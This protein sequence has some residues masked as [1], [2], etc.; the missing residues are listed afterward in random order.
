MFGLRLAYKQVTHKRNPNVWLQTS[1]KETEPKRYIGVAQGLHWGYI[2]VT[3]GLHWGYIY[4]KVFD[5]NNQ[6]VVVW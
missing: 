5:L 3:Q 2:E 4:F 1:Y 6:N